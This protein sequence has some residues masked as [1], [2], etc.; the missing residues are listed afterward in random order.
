[1]PPSSFQTHKNPRA[2]GSA[3]QSPHA[4]HRYSERTAIK[5]RFC[6]EKTHKPFLL[7]CFRIWAVGTAFCSNGS[8]TSG[9]E[10][11][12][13]NPQPAC[14]SGSLARTRC[15]VLRTSQPPSDLSSSAFIKRAEGWVR[16]LAF[17]PSSWKEQ[18][19]ELRIPSSP[20][21]PP[22]PFPGSAYLLRV[23]ERLPLGQGSRGT[24]C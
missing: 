23:H 10:R 15:V 16:A 20:F 8:P 12:C 4:V 11:K 3:E 19:S 24:W 18:G 6:C 1:M 5:L 17:D 22:E 21:L 9:G 7:K 14:G 2:S 13:K